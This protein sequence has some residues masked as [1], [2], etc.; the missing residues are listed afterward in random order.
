LRRDGRITG[1]IT[2]T[3]RDRGGRGATWRVVVVDASTDARVRGAPRGGGV[4][5]GAQ[6]RAACDRVL[7][8]ARAPSSRRG[9]ARI[10]RTYLVA[11][12]RVRGGSRRGAG[13]GDTRGRRGHGLA[14]RDGQ[15][16]ALREHLGGDAHLRTARP[17]RRSRGPRETE[18]RVEPTENALDESARGASATRVS[19]KGVER[20]R[21]PVD[22]SSARRRGSDEGRRVEN[23]SSRFKSFSRVADQALCHIFITGRL[24]D[25]AGRRSRQHNNNSQVRSRHARHRL[26]SDAPPL[27][28]S[29]RCF[30]RS[31]RL[32]S[33]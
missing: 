19:V 1:R 11:G 29:L 7:K 27:L 5:T 6:E 17:R 13:R 12:G 15:L 3:S 20:A 33:S 2:G 31:S 14:Q 24:N 4:F 16:L 21:A 30:L 32:C 22:V 8:M 10:G 28:K 23:D 26:L 18:T 9:G 25:E